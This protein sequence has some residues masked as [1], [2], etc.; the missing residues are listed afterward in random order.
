MIGR[1]ERAFFTY[2]PDAELQRWEYP[3]MSLQRNLK[4]LGT[5]GYQASRL[6]REFYVQFMEPTAGYV[7]RHLAR[8]PEYAELS[9]LL[10][11]HL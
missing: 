10:Q 3:R 9:K 5:F 6:G 1:M 7:R 4:A 11:R 2:H 8:L